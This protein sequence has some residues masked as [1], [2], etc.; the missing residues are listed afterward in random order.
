MREAEK[1]LTIF[2][3][4]RNQKH[5]NALIAY[6]VFLNVHLLNHF[7]STLERTNV[8]VNSFQTKTLTKTSYC[9]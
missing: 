8:F 5:A 4:L 1:F 7:R 3:M 2:N 9:Q 6:K